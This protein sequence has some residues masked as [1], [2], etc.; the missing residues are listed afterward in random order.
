[1]NYHKDLEPNRQV[2]NF[3]YGI[4]ECF[5]TYNKKVVSNSYAN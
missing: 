2:D 3:A 1:M 5:Y 4:K